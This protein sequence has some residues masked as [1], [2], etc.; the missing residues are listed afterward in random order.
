MA[1]TSLPDHLPNLRKGGKPPHPSWLPRQRR[2]TTPQMIG[3]YPDYDVLETAD[4]WDEATRKVVLSRLEPPAPL[5][6]FTA[7]EEPTLRA[8]C[9]TVLAQ[10]REPRVP[11]AESVDEKLAAGRLD[12]YQYAD[13]PD[14]RD[15]WRLVLRALDETAAK[16]GAASFVAAEPETREA[17]VD[18]FSK[19]ELEGGT[20][21]RL[22]VKRAWSVCMRMV[23]SGFYSHPWAWNEIGFGGPAYPRG[24]MRLG[25]ATGPAAVREPYEKRGATHEDPVR[26]VESGEL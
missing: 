21:Q 9:D 1:D 22:N 13:M 11:V 19:G 10:D 6:F 26:V 17:I 25:G 20:W 7:D 14:D 3:R 8:F 12:G 16:R 18:R 15:T 23:L 2:G 4:T 24:F 5:R